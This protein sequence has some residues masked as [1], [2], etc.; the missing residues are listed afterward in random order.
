MIGILNLNKPRGI[1]SRGALDLVKRLV[2][3]AKCGHAGTLDPLASGV[4]VVCVGKA[5]RLIDF[6]QQMPKQYRATFTFGCTS[7]TEDLEG[8]VTE[9][10]DAPTPSRSAVDEAC[11]RFVG[12]IEQRPPMFSALKVKGRPAYALARKGR[13][14]ELAAR[15]VMIHRLAVESYE[16][17]ELVLDIECSAGTYVRSLGRDIAESLG[18]GAV[19][20]ALVRTAVGPFAIERGVSPRELTRDNLHE[21]LRPA[22]AAVELL[23]RVTLSAEQVTELEYGRS[24]GA[25]S[26][27]T[28]SLTVALD[29]AGEMVALLEADAEGRLW[30]KVN[31]VGRG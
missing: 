18:T 1:T 15:P 2:R 6:V 29:P 30:P 14:V 23:P 9:L 10:V 28:G 12:T 8:E 25:T 20:S 11:A 17:P 27:R 21:H 5:T 16:Y 19:M 22:T 24:I 4:L 13:T 26:D 31:F 3:P 7:P